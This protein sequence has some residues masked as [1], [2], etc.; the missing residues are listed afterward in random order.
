MR[1]SA[2]FLAMSVA[3]ALS[4]SAVSAEPKTYNVYVYN[5]FYSQNNPTA[6]PP[7]NFSDEP[8]ILI[9]DTIRWVRI[10][11][12]HNVIASAGQAED[13]NS[14]GNVTTSSPYMHTFTHAGDF[15]YYCSHHG[16]DAG[17]G[18]AGGMYSAVHVLCSVVD[19]A[20]QGGEA[21]QDRR[22]DNNDFIVFIN[23]FFNGNATS[24]LGIQ[25]G[26]PGHDGIFDN[27]DF[28]VFINTFF[29]DMASCTG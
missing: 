7:T 6:N 17:N 29:A 18:F 19:V 8:T 16:F 23:Q 11:G 15:N 2:L 10:S 22:L 13:W 5:N 27:N 3:A 25:G 26:I 12:S 20:I 9:G 28:V 21:G 1:K 4:W 14:G 24:D